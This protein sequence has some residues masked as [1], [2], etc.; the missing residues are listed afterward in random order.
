MAM[1][2]ALFLLVT[3]GLLGCGSAEEPQ[4]KEEKKQRT[5][6]P[7]PVAKFKP[8]EQTK[9]EKKKQPGEAGPPPP[10]TFGDLVF[11]LQEDA[12]ARQGGS[13]RLDGVDPRIFKP[14]IRHERIRVIIAEQYKTELTLP[15]VL[16]LREELCKENQMTPAQVDAIKL[17]DIAEAFEKN[18]Q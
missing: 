12:K 6:R 16:K 17:D 18:P 14:D 5:S 11:A 7:V 9:N 15:S 2:K 8:V 13:G 10:Y 1:K 3:A 4:A